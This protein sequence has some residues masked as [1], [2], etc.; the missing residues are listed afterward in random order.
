MKSTWL[1]EICRVFLLQIRC[2]GVRN[3]LILCGTVSHCCIEMNGHKLPTTYVLNAMY[4]FKW[5]LSY[6]ESKYSA[7]NL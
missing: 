2:R 1:I 6:L 3:Q 5:N 7:R 4:D